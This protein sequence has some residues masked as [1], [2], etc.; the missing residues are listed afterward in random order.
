[1]ANDMYQER[2]NALYGSLSLL[3][4]ADEHFYQQLGYPDNLRSP[5]MLYDIAANLGVCAQTRVLDVGCGNGRYTCR[6]AARFGCQITAVDPFDERLQQAR[7]RAEREGVDSHIAFKQASSGAL[8][9]DDDAFD[10]IWC[11]GTI[12]HVPALQQGFNECARVLKAQGFMLMHTYFATEL[13]ELGEAAWLCKAMAFV[14]RNMYPTP[15]ET[16]CQMAGLR[17]HAFEDVGS[18]W[19]E[20]LGMKVGR[21]GSFL[22]QEVARLRRFKDEFVAAFGQH[23]YDTT[24]ALYLCHIYPLLGKMSEVIYTLLKP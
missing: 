11:R 3:P 6:L 16:A 14:Q 9:F 19:H 17:I 7:E 5:E 20:Y 18:E 15:V 1:M 23:C 2:L 13:L 21:Q 10:F 22:L 4:S 12:V 24:L 8:P